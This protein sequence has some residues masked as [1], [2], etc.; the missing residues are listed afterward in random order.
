MPIWEW[1][2]D[3]SS[4]SKAM[5]MALLVGSITAGIVNGMPKSDNLTVFRIA[6]FLGGPGN[7]LFLIL[8]NFL[9]IGWAWRKRLRSIISLTLKLDFFVWVVVQGTKLIHFGP[10]TRRPNG[11][12]G[13]FPSGHATHAFGM[14]FLLTLFFPRFSWVWYGLAAAISWSRVETDWHSGF[15]VTAGILFGVVIVCVLVGQWL[16]H[17]ESYIVKNTGDGYMDKVPTSQVPDAK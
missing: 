6:D 3:K 2:R 15:Q 12:A 16:K 7:N 8:T 13:G 1:M 14:A 10:W 4:W 9:I 11:G 17:P 5:A